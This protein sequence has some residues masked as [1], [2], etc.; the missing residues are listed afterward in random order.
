MPSCTLVLARLLRPTVDARQQDADRQ[1]P[2]RR[3]QR[4]VA[5]QL[6][7][8]SAA[9]GVAGRTVVHGRGRGGAGRVG[10]CRWCRVRIHAPRR[11]HAVHGLPQHA[12]HQAPVIVGTEL[13]H[14]GQ[15][16]QGAK[17]GVHQVAGRQRGRWGPGATGGFPSSA[18]CPGSCAP[19]GPERGAT[20][21]SWAGPHTPTGATLGG[22]MC[23]PAALHPERR[24]T[25]RHPHA[26]RGH[27]IRSSRRPSAG[28]TTCAGQVKCR[29]GHGQGSDS[30]A[31]LAHRRELHAVGP[32]SCPKCSYSQHRSAC[33][34][35]SGA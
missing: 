3:G 10:H 18:W 15:G 25:C 2:C 32:R 19:H 6:A 33:A 1:E 29:S 8:P 34:F 11:L 22:G 13:Q 5:G 17:G 20:L 26:T 14:L 23:A 7:T 27:R 16:Q 21:R 12:G 24:S 28:K 30:Q 9:S 31:R 4:R 35:R